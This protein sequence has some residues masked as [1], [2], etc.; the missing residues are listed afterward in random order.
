MVRKFG[1]GFSS[2]GRH[3]LIWPIR[4]CTAEQGM[5]FMVSSLKKG[6]KFHY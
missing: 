6:I 1:M 5:V 3:S 4:V 2:R